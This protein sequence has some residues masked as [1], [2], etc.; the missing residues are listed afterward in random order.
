[1]MMNMSGVDNSVILN[2]KVQIELERLMD[3]CEEEKI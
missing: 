2:E 3:E 1:M